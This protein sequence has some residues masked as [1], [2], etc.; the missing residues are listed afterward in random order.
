MAIKHLKHLHAHKYCSDDNNCEMTNA[1]NL[2]DEERLRQFRI[3]FQECLSECVRFL[4]EIEGLLTGDGLC[5]RMMDHLQDH[6]TTLTD[7]CKTVIV[8]VFGLMWMYLFVCSD[9]C[10]SNAKH[11][12]SQQQNGNQQQTATIR[13][14]NI[15]Q[16]EFNSERRDAAHCDVALTGNARKRRQHKSQT[17]NVVV[18]WQLHKQQ[19]EFAR[20]AR[21]RH[22]AE[23]EQQSSVE[24][25]LVATEFESNEWSVQFQKGNQRTLHSTA[26]AKQWECY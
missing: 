10:E 12:Q 18:C 20:V 8:F 4:V 5:R 2:D 21:R 6:M 17:E 15:E 16:C 3:G 24:R 22:F 19:Y 23:F 26:R 1:P 14:I 25:E 9:Q 7:N 13:R 11:R